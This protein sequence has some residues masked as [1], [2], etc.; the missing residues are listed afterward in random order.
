MHWFI[1]FKN[2]KEH[3]LRACLI[4][5][6]TLSK[7]WKSVGWKYNYICT[8]KVSP[9]CVVCACFLT[10]CYSNSQGQSAAKR[11]G[12]FKKVLNVSF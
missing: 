10:V 2:L 8:E 12:K 7:R 4:V 11:Q 6:V 5:D 1:N 3:A 9:S